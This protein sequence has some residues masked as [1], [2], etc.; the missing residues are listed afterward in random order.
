MYHDGV[1]STQL[2]RVEPFQ[3]LMIDTDIWRDAHEYHRR[4]QQLHAVLLHG[5]GIVRGLDVGP[6]PGAERSLTIG[7]GVALDPE[8]RLILVSR[9]LRYQVNATSAGLVYL[10]LTARDIPS[11]PLLSLED[12][13]RR[14]SRMVEGYALAEYDHLPDTP[15]V[16][17]ARIRLSS[18]KKPITSAANPGAPDANEIDLR[19]RI[20]AALRPAPLSDIGCWTPDGAGSASAT[21][22][23]AGLAVLVREL[24]A[25]RR[26][27]RWRDAV[28]DSTD[29]LDGDLLL[30][31]LEGE[32][33]LS[34]ADQRRLTVFLDE[35]GVI[36]A[37]PCAA[38]GKKA[39]RQSALAA[40]AERLGRAPQPV[41]YGHPLL[42]AAHIFAAPPPGLTDDPVQEAGGLVLSQADYACAWKGGNATHPLSRDVIRTAQEFGENLLAYARQRRRAW[43]ATQ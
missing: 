30:L 6:T 1:P 23:S 4:A 40:L 5:S 26:Q 42:T 11:D 34:E 13:A 32:L 41:D 9:S 24:A 28:A 19:Y 8:G 21:E 15:H 2:K 25:S 43:E 17:L 10:I 22:H 36:L 27:I 33:D 16:E 18:G 12:G 29:P 38:Q 39:D 14:P 31:P 37:E 35:G 7:P 3:G 20:E